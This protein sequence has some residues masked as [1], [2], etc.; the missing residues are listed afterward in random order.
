MQGTRRSKK[1]AKTPRAAFLTAMYAAE[2]CGQPQQVGYDVMSHS[3]RLHD[4][5]TVEAN[6]H[7]AMCDACGNI[8]TLC[9]ECVDDAVAGELDFWTREASK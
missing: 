1:A 7:Y 4:Y 8:D 2:C 9:N 3:C 5:E 6:C